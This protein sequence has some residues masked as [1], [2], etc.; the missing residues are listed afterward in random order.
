MGHQVII[1]PECTCNSQDSAKLLDVCP[2]PWTAPNS[3]KKHWGSW[4]LPPFIKIPELQVRH[5]S[6]TLVAIKASAEKC[7]SFAYNYSK[8]VSG[9]VGV[10]C[11]SSWTYMSN[12]LPSL[13]APWGERSRLLKLSAS[14]MACKFNKVD[15][16]N[17][18]WRLKIR[19][20]D[21]LNINTKCPARTGGL[22]LF[23]WTHF[24][25]IMV[26]VTSHEFL[27]VIETFMAGFDNQHLR[28]PIMLSSAGLKVIHGWKAYC[29]FASTEAVG[30]HRSIYSIIWG[31]C[32]C[33][34]C[35][36]I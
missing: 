34:Q 19:Y 17:R 20:M 13:K 35:L 8:L 1:W 25:H 10:S 9:A 11:E 6:Y 15:L 18:E 26:M 7:C 3:L 31:S 23:W 29:C 30:Y 22:N 24:L 14:R 12:A 5:K 28:G 32:W 16:Y 21:L 33:A 4:S 27:S 2:V 36:N